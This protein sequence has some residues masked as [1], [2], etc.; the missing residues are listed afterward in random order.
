MG[1]INKALERIKDREKDRSRGAVGATRANAGNIKREFEAA[2][3]V[4]RASATKVRFDPDNLARNRIITDD[5]DPGART[6]YKML[7][8]RLLQVMRTNNWQSIAVTSAAQGD[9]K[10]VT[11][12]NLAI[13][14][15]GDVNHGVCLVDLD[16]RRS[17]IAEYLGLSLKHGVS[18]CLRHNLPI[19]E[20][21]VEP[22]IDRLLILPNKATVTHSSEILSSP[23]MQEFARDL[24]SDPSRIVIYDM[25]PVLAADDMLAFAPNIDAVL[26]VV[27]KGRTV[28]TDVMKAYELLEDVHIIGTVFN[29]S[30]EKSASYY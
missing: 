17:S 23:R 20:A 26:F 11:A 5:M 2:D 4:L 8:T 18:D 29:G 24:A 10:T 9:G 3:D 25:P 12:I 7:R 6:A 19:A 13:S 30:D 22:N 21:I 28:R 14:I 15:S 16:L 27:A 1:R